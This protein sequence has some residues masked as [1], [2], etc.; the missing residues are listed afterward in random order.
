MTANLQKLSMFHFASVSKIN[1]LIQRA[2]LDDIASKR[3]PII[4]DQRLA[5]R[6]RPL[7]ARLLAN[8]VGWARGALGLDIMAR[9]DRLQQIHFYT[10]PLWRRLTRLTGDDPQK[11]GLTK[12]PGN[13]VLVRHRSKQRHVVHALNHEFIHALAYQMISVDLSGPQI[14]YRCSRAGLVNTRSAA[15]SYFDEVIVELLNLELLRQLE[16]GSRGGAFY[17]PEIK[18]G[19]PN[20]LLFLDTVIQDVAN[21]Y[22]VDPQT[23]YLALFRGLLTGSWRFPDRLPRP[24]LRSIGRFLLTCPPRLAFGIDDFAM[25]AENLQLDITY[26]EKR[27]RSLMNHGRPVTLANGITLHV[28]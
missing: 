17:Y 9:L 28:P 19:S 7:I 15:G 27:I 10:A 11:Q 2:I 3:P 1:N 23:L 20:G 6:Y 22:P 5:K 26:L 25:I 21:R 12:Y 24:L 14:I 16:T 13:L 8:F 18:V 4:G